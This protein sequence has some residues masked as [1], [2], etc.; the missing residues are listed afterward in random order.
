MTINQFLSE[1]KLKSDTI[2]FLSIQHFLMKLYKDGDEITNIE[3]TLSNYPLY[4]RYLND[5]AGKIYKQ[6]D[7]SIYEIYN[8]TC[9]IIGIEADN[10]YLFNYRLAR[11]ELND[12]ERIMNIQNEDIKLQTV[13][14]QFDEFQKV[15]SSKFYQENK[16]Q[17]KQNI[18]KLERQF[19]I[20]KQLV[21]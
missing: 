5:F 11:L 19:E 18:V 1:F 20:L 6:Y 2:T 9:Q 4:L 15:I 10:Q 16:E 17:Y 13:E 21:N 3:E 14:K 8:N 12:I 7:S